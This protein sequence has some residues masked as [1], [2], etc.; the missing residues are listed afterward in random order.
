MKFYLPVLR[1]RFGRDVNNFFL[2][3]KKNILVSHT[4]LVVYFE[5]ATETA[6]LSNSFWPS[7]LSDILY[8]KK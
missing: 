8:N 4:A 7:L 6:T 5:N 1:V 2:K 3:K